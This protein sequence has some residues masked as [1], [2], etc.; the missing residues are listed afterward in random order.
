L[1]QYREELGSKIELLHFLRSEPP[2]GVW[3]GGLASR[4]VFGTDAT[5]TTV[6]FLAMGAH[7]DLGCLRGALV[8]RSGRPVPAGSRTGVR[9]YRSW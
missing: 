1:D 9:S 7:S 8:S 6:H 4:V 5:A 3:V 2:N